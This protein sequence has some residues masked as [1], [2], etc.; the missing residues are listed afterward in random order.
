IEAHSGLSGLIAEETSVRKGDSIKSFD[1]MWVSSL[2]DSTM[3]G[4]PDIELVDMTS[5]IK[6][7][8]EILDVTTKPII[9]DGDTGGLPEH[10]EYNIK[11][12]E[13]IGVSAVIIEDKT[14]L[15]RN[16]LFGTEVAQTQDEPEHFAE[17]IRIGKK[18]LISDDFM[19]IARIESLIL[20]R[21]MKDALMRAETYLSAGA[22]AIMIHSRKKTPDEIF[23]FSDS[24]RRLFPESPLVVVPTTYS[25]VTE[26]ELPSHGINIAIYANH[27]IRSAY[28]A[29][30]KTAESILLNG[31]AK[32]ASDAYCQPI[33]DILSILPNGKQA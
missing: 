21:G 17:K 19:L 30:K 10:F 15:K 5:R 32:E 13:R 25:S 29:M 33:K 26:D 31:R 22:D 9:L 27:L 3:K 18:A 16:S 1:G 12:I 28:P 20:E 11:T 4:K 8:D 6:T 7:I 14:G 2:C 24:F 23:E